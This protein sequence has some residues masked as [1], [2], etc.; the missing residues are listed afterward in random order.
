LRFFLSHLGV[1]ETRIDRIVV[2]PHPSEPRDKYANVSAEFGSHVVMG[3][4]RP[5]LEE[6]ADSDIVAGCESMAM[7]VALVAGRR[8]ISCIPPGGKPCAL[9]HAEI[10][11]LQELVAARRF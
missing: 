10:E 6:I 8:V 2:R 9:P 11:S 7:V 3:G 4:N 1:L 5:L